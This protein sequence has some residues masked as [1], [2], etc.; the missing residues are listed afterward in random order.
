[1]RLDGFSSVYGNW[2]G[3][4]LLTKPFIFSGE[5]LFVNFSTSAAGG[6]RIEIT[7]M[8]GNAIDGFERENS[9]ELIGNEIE[10]EVTWNRKLNLKK[11]SGKK[12][13]LRV[14]LSDAHVYSFRFE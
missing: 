10:K 4:E 8:D 12:V 1:M 9:V 2:D 6:V 5:K 7:D 14:L 11:L 13:R 3:G